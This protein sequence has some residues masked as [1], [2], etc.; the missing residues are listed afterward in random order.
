MI[1]AAVLGYGT[2]GSGVVRII[3]ENNALISKRIG[4][5][6]QVKYVLDLREFEGDPVQKI[7]VHDYEVIRNDADVSIVVETMGG[8]H[9]AYEF[10]KGALEAGKNVCTSNKA[11][12]AAYGPELLAV[13]KE[14]SVNFLFEASV[15]GGIPIIRPLKTSLDPDDILE[16]SGIL[17]G[18]TNYILSKMSDEGLDFADVLK[19]AQERGFA[20]RNP[21]A[22][23]EGYDAARKIAILV[24]LAYG[25]TVNWENILTEGITNIS[26]RDIVYAKKMKKKIKIT[27]TGRKEGDKV[28][29]RV[30]PVLISK[31]NP[32]YNVDGVYNAILV[33]GNMVGDVMFYGQGAGS[34]P[35]ASAVVSDVMDAA[36]HLNININTIWE[37]DELELVPHSQM[38]SRFFIRIRG[39]EKV[40]KEKVTKLFGQVEEVYAGYAD[41]Y[42]F[43]TK[44]ITESEYR[45]AADDL[46]QVINK[47]RLG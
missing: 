22:D 6:I 8:L 20:E 14:K 23:I 30:A 38:K 40:L 19:D 12:V 1:N 25:K 36:R 2:V 37:P 7:L 42:A 15:G 45:S 24:S 27:G 4:D 34:L 28:M 5:D 9:P 44:E 29:V 13:A 41:E 33:R 39:T 35:T 21:E 17:N 16:I 43:I 3:N 31:D 46:D 47:I 26:D 10:V 11:L 18:T 32:L